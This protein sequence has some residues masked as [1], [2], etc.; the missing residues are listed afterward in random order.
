MGGEQEMA[1]EVG[2][3]E[4]QTFREKQGIGCCPQTDRVHER[5]IGQVQVYVSSRSSSSRGSMQFRIL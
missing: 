4:D 1:E 3:T 5:D 2:L